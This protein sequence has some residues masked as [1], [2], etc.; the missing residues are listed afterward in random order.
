V[1]RDS[2]LQGNCTDD[3]PIKAKSDIELMNSQAA[4]IINKYPNCVEPF[5]EKNNPIEH[6]DMEVINKLVK[7]YEDE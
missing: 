4:N 2:M 7:G 5:L 3:R 1:L 6:A